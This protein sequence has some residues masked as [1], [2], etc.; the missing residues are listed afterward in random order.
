MS[1]SELCWNHNFFSFLIY[2]I[3]ETRQVSRASIRQRNRISRFT[4]IFSLVISGK[5]QRVLLVGQFFLAEHPDFRALPLSSDSR[6]LYGGEMV[7]ILSPLRL[8]VNHSYL[9]V[10]SPAYPSQAF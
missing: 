7:S 8:S 9:L 3:L 4:A 2:I 10:F 6:K 1:S 5:H